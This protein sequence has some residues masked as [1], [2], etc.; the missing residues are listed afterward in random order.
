MKKKLTI[1]FMLL[2]VSIIAAPPGTQSNSSPEFEVN[3]TASISKNGTVQDQIDSFLD[4]KGWQT[5]ENN[6]KGKKIFISTGAGTIGAPQNN[7][8]YINS[9]INAF[10]KA[11]LVAKRE[12]VEYVGAEIAKS[13]ELLTSQPAESPEEENKPTLIKDKG[14]FEKAKMLLNSKLDKALKAEGIED[15]KNATPEEIKK[16]VE[17][18]SFK[19][20]THTMATSLVSGMQVYKTFEV[21][22]PN[23]KGEVGVICIYSEKLQK[24][25]ESLVT[26][27][28]MPKSVPKK[29]IIEQIPT[30]KNVLLSSFGVQQKINEN[31]NLVLIAYGQGSIRTKSPTSKRIAFRKAK[32]A[33][34]SLI[35]QFAGEAFATNSDMNNAETSEQYDNET[36][37]YKDESS[38]QDKIKSASDSMKISGISVIKKWTAKHPLNGQTVCGVVVAWSPD[39]ADRAK[40]LGQK[41]NTPPSSQ[42]TSGKSS[43]SNADMSGSYSSGGAQA[44]DDAF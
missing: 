27:E 29:P 40:S 15:P 25:A 30:D 43:A 3:N 34:M 23:Q 32:M 21:T 33:A 2:S 18:E 37:G 26:G 14:L 36:S 41:L 44:D 39:S 16:V 8:S 4:S 31:G 5:G 12:M 22:P 9:R 11:L 35:R 20:T 1:L 24:M 7:K 28:A 17:S 6:Q 19:S 38:F 10:E 13:A 42:S